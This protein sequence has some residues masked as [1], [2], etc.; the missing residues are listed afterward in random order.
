MSYR[1]TMQQKKDYQSVFYSM[2][3][4]LGAG[5]VDI[6][7]STDTENIS[8]KRWRQKMNRKFRAL[9]L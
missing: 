8:L 1:K 9:G 5:G 4:N 6:L 7:K 2:S 3:H